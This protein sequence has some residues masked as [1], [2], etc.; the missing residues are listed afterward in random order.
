MEKTSGRF[1]LKTEPSQGMK[2]IKGKSRGS[3]VLLTFWKAGVA[4][5]WGRAGAVVLAL[6]H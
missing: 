4:I 5:F 2:W 1:T 6:E 3:E